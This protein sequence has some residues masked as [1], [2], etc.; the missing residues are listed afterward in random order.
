MIHRVIV[1]G[2]GS[3]G[4][5]AAIT[6]KKKLP[7]LSVTVVRSKEI[8]VIG[9]GESTTVALPDHLHGYLDLDIA[10]FY[11]KVLPSWKLGI[12]FLW[13][14]RPFFDYAFSLQ[15]DWKWERLAKSNGYY[16]EED[17]S[18]VDVLAA[19]MAHKKAFVRQP[20]GNPL[21]TRNFGYHIENRR[22]VA[23]L[24]E[25]ATQ[26]GI[27][28]VEDVLTGVEQDDNG[29]TVLH[30][31]SGAALSAD[32][33][34]DCSGFRSLL[35][36]QALAAPYSSF[37]STLF[38]DRAVTT[39]W[40][41]TD[42]TINPYTTAESMSAGWCWQIDH[43]DCIAR[44]Y[45]YSS[46]FISDAEA[47]KEF[48]DKNPKVEWTRLV[49]F[50][51]GRFE[52]SWVKNVVALG[53]AAGF[54]EPLESTALAVI[55]DESR[56]LAECLYESDR[57]PGPSLA[58]HYNRINARMWDCIRDFLGIHYK[59]NTRFETPFWRACRADVELGSVQELVDYY[60]ENGPSTFAR[61]SLIRANDFS[62][63]EGYYVLLV[64]QKVPYRRRHSPTPHEWRVW[65][66][67]RAENRLKALT[68]L[69]VQ[70][71]LD[72]IAAPTWKWPP[73]F[74]R[75]PA[76]VAT[77]VSHLTSFIGAG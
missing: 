21:I 49:Q 6:L 75:T 25:K 53:N 16:C 19:L 8:G 47:E 45:V 64:G 34:L 67:I 54:V 39:A 69:S 77:S 60:R 4:F 28:C 23:Y 61:D 38:C 12:R 1:L 50:R 14:P 20:N 31:A 36:G 29:I 62:G 48:R 17:F 55:C 37:R 40:T 30:L 35:L 11:Q 32:L 2:G 72:A 56:L 15:M 74:Y 26:I 24:E 52:R 7:E 68:A 42:E 41:R 76:P 13:G 71:A 44:G 43:P 57:Q 58:D 18:Y 27:V 65:Q 51:S 10:E 22:F 3:A 66:G 59:F 63:I 70:E 73:G 9:V 46:A 33:Y 5:L